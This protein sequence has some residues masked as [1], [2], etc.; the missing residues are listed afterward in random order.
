[1][2]QPSPVKQTHFRGPA[3]PET[4]E[5][6]CLY[7]SS[8]QIVPVGR[9][10]AGGGTIKEEVRCAACRTLFVVVRTDR[11]ATAGLEQATREEAVRDRLVVTALRRWY[12]Q[13]M[14]VRAALV[15]ALITERPLC[16]GCIAERALAPVDEVNALFQR[17]QELLQ[18]QR[19]ESARCHACGLVCA[20]F[21][22]KLP[23][24]ALTLHPESQ[25]E[26]P[27]TSALRRP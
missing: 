1:M 11:N 18:V 25:P 2:N 6:R 19:I 23:T 15:T 21:V 13:R 27:M 8:E 22:V 17:I 20:V 14:P 12:A 26:A 16:M 3:L 5:R 24:H 10:V 7:C 9:V 4:D